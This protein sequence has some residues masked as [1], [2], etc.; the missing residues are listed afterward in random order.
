MADGKV[1]CTKCSKTYKTWQSGKQHYNEVHQ[2]TV[3]AVCKICQRVFKNRRSRDNHYS[4][5]HQLSATAMKNTIVPSQTAQNR[6]PIP[7]NRLPLPGYF[8]KPEN[9][10]NI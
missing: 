2:P 6:V 9:P 3:S 10:G 5:Q 1:F 8:P 4:Q 7:E